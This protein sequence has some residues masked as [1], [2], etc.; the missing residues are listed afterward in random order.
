MINFIIGFFEGMW[1][2]LYQLYREITTIDSN[3]LGMIAGA[4]ITIVAVVMILLI[5]FAFFIA[6]LN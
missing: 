4:L 2:V 5:I 3:E 1:G 6:L